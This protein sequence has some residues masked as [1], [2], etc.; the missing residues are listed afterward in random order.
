MTQ[1]EVNNEGSMKNWILLKEPI[2]DNAVFSRIEISSFPVSEASVS[3][4]GRPESDRYIQMITKDDTELKEADLMGVDIRLDENGVKYYD[5]KLAFS[6]KKCSYEESKY[7]WGQ[8]PIKTLAYVSTT[9][10]EGKL[11]RFVARTNLDQWGNFAKQQ[12]A[13]WKSFRVTTAVSPST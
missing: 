2:S 5:Y 3:D 9:V 8:C 7:A 10:A 6:P 1:T 4:F 12:P 13:V 11:F